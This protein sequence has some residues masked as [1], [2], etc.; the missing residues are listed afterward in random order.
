MEN[1]VFTSIIV[2]RK[3]DTPGTWAKAPKNNMGIIQYAP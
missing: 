3:D 1:N 2:K